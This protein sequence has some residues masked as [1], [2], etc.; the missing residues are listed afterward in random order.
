MAALV[1]GHLR[2][3]TTVWDVTAVAWQR[4]AHNKHRKLISLMPWRPKGRR[5]LRGRGMSTHKR[6][7]FKAGRMLFATHPHNSGPQDRG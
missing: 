6:H 2:Y 4:S 5:R 7:R 3:D 1:I